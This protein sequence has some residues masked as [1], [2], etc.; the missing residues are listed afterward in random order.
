M[1]ISCELI[2]AVIVI[3][4]HPHRDRTDERDSIGS[5]NGLVLSGIPPYWFDVLTASKTIL[6]QREGIWLKLRELN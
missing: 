6:K 2:L 1:Y 3:G 4:P 5:G